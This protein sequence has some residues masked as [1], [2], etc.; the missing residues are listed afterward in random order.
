MRK[1][2]EKLIGLKRIT[3]TSKKD[4]SVVIISDCMV[5]QYLIDAILSVKDINCEMIYIDTSQKKISVLR[6]HMSYLVLAIVVRLNISKYKLV[7]IWQ[8]YIAIYYSI[9]FYFF[10]KYRK[11]VLVTPMIFIEKNGYYGLIKKKIFNVMT[12]NIEIFKIICHSFWEETNYRKIF[13]QNDMKITYLPLWKE[14]KDNEIAKANMNYFFSGGTS[15]RDYKTLI[16]AAK[17]V[18]EKFIIACKRK[19]V[20][21]IDIPGNVKLIFDAYHNEFDILLKMSKG[22][23]ILLDN[24]NV[25]A[26]QMVALRA[27]SLNKCII[28]TKTKGLMP[29]IDEN[30]G[31]LVNMRDVDEVVAAIKMFENKSMIMEKEMNSKIKYDKGKKWFVNC[32]REIVIEKVKHGES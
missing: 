30:N 13:Y 9:I 29:Y 18:K 5:N 7:I 26:G 11:K 6:R 28:A 23:V 17:K 25:S 19:D 4:D 10:E 27:M 16:Q 32:I 15:C 22:V 2:I 24:A 14:Y 1:M 8:Q 12:N 3:Y 31:F 21:G 20:C